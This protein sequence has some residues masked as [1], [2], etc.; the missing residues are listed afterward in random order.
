MQRPLRGCRP[1]SDCRMRSESSNR[2]AFKF[3]GSETCTTRI[4]PPPR[5]L[6]GLRHAIRVSHLTRR[7]TGSESLASAPCGEEGDSGP[8]RALSGFFSLYVGLGSSNLIKIGIIQVDCTCGDTRAGPG[9]AHPR[10]GLGP[11]S[12]IAVSNGQLAREAQCESHCSSVRARHWHVR[13]A[14]ALRG[15]REGVGADGSGRVSRL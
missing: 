2:A 10:A 13:I 11:P 14:C 3:S 5:A 7:P 9:R 1:D 8:R 12:A 6:H 4:G 15:V